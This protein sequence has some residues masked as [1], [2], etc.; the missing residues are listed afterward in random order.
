MQLNS[1]IEEYTEAKNSFKKKFQESLKNAFR[2][3]FDKSPEAN[4]I[5]WDQYTPYFMDGEPCVFGVHSIVVT[6][7]SLEEASDIRWGEYDG[8]NEDIWTHATYQK[9]DPKINFDENLFKAISDTLCTELGEEMLLNTFG[10]H[11]RVIATRE[12]FTVEECD[13]D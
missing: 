8:D 9:K 5:V 2:E 4:C 13:H 10:D 6:N 1:I 7:A 12:G 3:F 11:C